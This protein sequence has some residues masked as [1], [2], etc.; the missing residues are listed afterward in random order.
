[1]RIHII[2]EGDTLEAIATHY[3]VDVEAIERSNQQVTNP[4]MIVPGIK[5]MI[6]QQSKTLQQEEQRSWKNKNHNKAHQNKQVKQ[7]QQRRPIGDMQHDEWTHVNQE[8]QVNMQ[9]KENRSDYESHSK[10]SPT[11][12][13]IKASPRKKDPHDKHIYC[14]CCHRPIYFN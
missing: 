6:P 9:Q 8:Q 14:D 5:L 12:N 3:E 10:Q 4:N 2:Q 11:I 1:M 7:M 13:D